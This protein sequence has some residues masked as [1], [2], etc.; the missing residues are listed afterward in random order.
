[1]HGAEVGHGRP[2]TSL[3]TL[4]EFPRLERHPAP[5]RCWYAPCRV[6]ESVLLTQRLR[7]HTLIRLI[8]LSCSAVCLAVSPA[9]A[10]D[11]VV[12]AYTPGPVGFNIATILAPA[13]VRMRTWERGAGLTLACGTGA[14][15]VFAVGRRLGK[16]ES[17]VRLDLPG[18][19]LTLAEGAEG[20]LLMSGPATHVFSGEIDLDR[21]G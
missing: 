5:E 6:V 2:L 3:N 20:H 19:A 10:Q 9:A 16:L 21:L 18:G 11:L 13:H 15:A 8:I 17:E 1:V 14:C 4:E 12:G 7:V